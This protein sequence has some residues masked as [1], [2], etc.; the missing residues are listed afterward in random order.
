MSSQTHAVEMFQK[1]NTLLLIVIGKIWLLKMTDL[2]VKGNESF[3]SNY[4]CS[5][6]FCQYAYNKKSPMCCYI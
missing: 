4:F 1:Q 5:G 2:N 3:L 6:K